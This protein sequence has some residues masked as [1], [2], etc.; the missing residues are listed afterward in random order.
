MGAFFEKPLTGETDLT[1]KIFAPPQT[2]E[3]DTSTED[4][5]YNTYTTIEE[6]PKIRIRFEP[7]ETSRD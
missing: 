4:G 2:G 6:L 7:V 1:L 5:L 3:N